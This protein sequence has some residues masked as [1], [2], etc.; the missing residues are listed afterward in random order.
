LSATII[1]IHND[2]GGIFSFLPQAAHPEHFEELFGTPHGLDFSHAAKMY[3]AV[4][5]EPKTWSEFRAAAQTGIASD[6]LCI[7]QVK[8]DRTRNVTMHRQ[9]WSAVARALGSPGE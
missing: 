4:W 1:L 6:G 5:H 2:G 7:V 8:T 9:V 3:G